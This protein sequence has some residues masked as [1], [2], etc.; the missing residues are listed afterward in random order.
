MA[1][2]ACLVLDEVHAYEPY[3]LGLLVEA[4][5]REPPAALALASATLPSTLLSH[6][7]AGKL[8]EAEPTL[9]RRSRHT[10]DHRDE[11]LADAGVATA[12]ARARAGETVLVVANTVT[13]A[14]AIYRALRDDYEHDP[15]MLLHSRFTFGDR[16]LKE[17]EVQTPEPGTIV[18]ATQVVE[19]SLDISY[20]VLLTEIAPIDALVQRMGRVN[21]QGERETALVAVY[22]DWSA[23]AEY[24]YGRLTLDTSAA[25]IDDL[26]REPDDGDLATATHRLYEH[27]MPSERWQ[28]DLHEGRAMLAEVQERLG[29]ETID[30]SD[31]EMR[32]RFASR[33]G[34]VS[35][36]VLPSVFLDEADRLRRT[37]QGWRLPELLVPVP[38]YWLQRAPDAFDALT[39]LALYNA[40]M[41]YSWEFGLSPPEDGEPRRGARIL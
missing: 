1:A 8:V 34:Q 30:L 13:D 39:D 41:P 22:G 31:E 28:N 3:T 2:R 15:S 23:G 35:L 12:V 40:N 4:L 11:A 19:V 37:G 16:R 27:V 18:V 21:R 33:R 6:F 14:Q 7:P 26:P 17:A 20:D 24:V 29:C 5:E 38:A 9:W 36:E 10:L 25:L 32:S